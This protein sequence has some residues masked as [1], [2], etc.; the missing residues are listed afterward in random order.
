MGMT[1]RVSE[2]TTSKGERTTLRVE[3]ALSL[4]DAELIEKICRG[5]RRRSGTEITL[6]LADLSFLDSEGARL[7]CRIKAEQDLSFTGLNLFIQGVIEMADR[8]EKQKANIQG[9]NPG[10]E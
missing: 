5:L 10:G 6:D 9:K 2:V 3:G 7:L 8:E 1:I 4:E